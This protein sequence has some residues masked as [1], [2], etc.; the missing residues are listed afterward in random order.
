M[1]E[2]SQAVMFEHSQ[3]PVT[4]FFVWVAEGQVRH[5]EADEQVAH[6]E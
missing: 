2:E 6:E 5:A 1:V 4:V 3:M